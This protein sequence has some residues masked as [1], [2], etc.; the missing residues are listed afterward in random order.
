MINLKN[1][2]V[3]IWGLGIVGTS[4][5]SYVKKHT[6]DIQ[7]LDKKQH[8]KLHV[9]IQT[10]Q[11][12]QAFLEH[13]DIIIPSPGISLLAYQNYAHKF[14]HELDIFSSHIDTPTIAITGTLGKT[15]ITSFI[16]QC[17]PHSVAAGNIGYAMLNALE[18]PNKP[19][20]VVLELSSYQLQ[21]AKNFAPDI[22]L[23]TNFYPNHLDHHATIE[24]YLS[25][26]CQMFLHQRSN[27]IAIIPYELINQIE[28]T[29]TI[30]SLVYLFS[31]T[32]PTDTP[33]YPTFYIEN[34]CLMIFKKLLDPVV[35]PQEIRNDITKDTIIFNSIDQLP[36]T[37]FLQNWVAILA[38]LYLYKIPLH[39]VSFAA[40]LQPEHRIEF[41]GNFHNVAIY[42]DSKSTVWQATQTAL[43]RFLDKKIAV[44]VGGLSKGTDRSPLIE[45]CKDKNITVFTFGG[46]A[47]KISDLCTQYQVPCAQATDLSHIL[48]LFK[49]Q[50]KNF[51]ILLFSPAGASFD[52]FKNFEDRGTQFKTLVKEMIKA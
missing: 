15:T 4:V 22:A 25:A 29:I 41:V 21:Y 52:L 28:A 19:Q 1:K 51:D 3:G 8:E 46:E 43:Q 26:K 16:Q 13:N 30:P 10:P 50:Y 18:L 32:K 31:V 14:V 35:K 23:L 40:L 6:T 24:E 48:D 12:V 42:N 11:S 34:N 37:T 20:T 27:Q 36:N 44:I 39:S 9:I 5:L 7:I 33:K 49:S 38:T 17:I 47:D 45:F 2:R